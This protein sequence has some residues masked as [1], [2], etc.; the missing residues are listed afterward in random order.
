MVRV[1]ME[2]LWRKKENEM[3]RA[4]QNIVFALTGLLLCWLPVLVGFFDTMRGR[5]SL[6]ECQVREWKRWWSVYEDLR[7]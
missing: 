4:L 7:A 1:L 5:G 2:I 6:V 3:L